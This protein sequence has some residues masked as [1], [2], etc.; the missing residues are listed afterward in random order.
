MKSYF[1]LC[2]FEASVKEASYLPMLLSNK[3]QD[4]NKKSIINPQNVKYVTA[5]MA[6]CGLYNESG[7]HFVKTGMPSKS[8]V[9]GFII[10]AALG[11][12]GIAVMS[13]KINSKGTS[14]RGE[15]ILTYLS[16]KLSLHFGS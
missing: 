14:I 10:S 4:E 1:S 12:A 16:E 6:T 13:P 15:M 5:L 11:K 7:S 2:S 8:G 9:S 3:G